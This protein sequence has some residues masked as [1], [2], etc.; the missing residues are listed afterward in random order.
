MDLPASNVT[1]AN[2][3]NAVRTGS[4]PNR[5][6]DRKTAG[7][8]DVKQ[9]RLKVD[10]FAYQIGGGRRVASLKLLGTCSRLLCP[11]YMYQGTDHSDILMRLRNEERDVVKVSLVS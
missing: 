9:M 3:G 4:R 5:T 8:R 7:W 11:W 2:I 6:T 1:Y 10:L